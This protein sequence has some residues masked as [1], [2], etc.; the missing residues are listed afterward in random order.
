MAHGFFT[1]PTVFDAGADAVRRV[2]HQL[3]PLIAARAAAAR[4]V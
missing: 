1:R 2:A 3:R 4:I